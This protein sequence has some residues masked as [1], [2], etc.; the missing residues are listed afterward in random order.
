MFETCWVCLR[1]TPEYVMKHAYKVWSEDKVLA[2]KIGKLAS[3]IIEEKY[4]ENPHFFCGHP[5]RT[6]VGSLF[7]VLCPQ[8]S[9]YSKLKAKT[10]MD[11]AFPFNMS[12]VSVRNNYLRWLRAFPDL[13]KYVPHMRVKI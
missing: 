5:A 12:E 9:H 13:R 8:N 10:Q 4:K 2:R 3:E 11:V 1:I 7:Y 6:I